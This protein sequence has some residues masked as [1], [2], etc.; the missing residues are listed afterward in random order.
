ME[1]PRCR[2]KLRAV[3]VITNEAV[4]RKILAHLKMDAEGCVVAEARGPPEVEADDR[5]QA[6]FGWFNQLKAPSVALSL[7]TRA[8]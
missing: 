1:C 3:G 4:A 2:G 6:P 5:G 7:K 8:A